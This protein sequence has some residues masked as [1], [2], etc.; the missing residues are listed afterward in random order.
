[1]NVRR[2]LARLTALVVVVAMPAMGMSGIASAKAGKAGPNCI[3]HPTKPKCLNASGG[4]S[5]TGGP[6]PQI[7]VQVDPQ[8]VVETGQSEVHIVIQVETLASFAGDSVNID[9]SQL[10]SSCASL[11][12]ESL[13]IGGPQTVPPITAVHLH[14]ISAVLDDDGN[15]TVV[16]NG[17]DCAPGTDVI[18]ADL[19][20]SPFLTALTTLTVA[21]PA[22]TP[23]GVS[24]HPQFGGLNQEV[25]TGDTTTSGDSDIYAVFYVE[26]NPVYA[27]QTVEIS[28]AQ[29]EARCIEGWVWEAGNPNGVGVGGPP[30]TPVLG[31]GANTNP[32]AS[33]I[34][35][36]DGN[37]V[38]IFKGA[39]CA[40]G[41]SQVIAD[42]LAG[43]HPTYTVQFTVLAP[44]VTI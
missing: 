36:D 20:V 27:E 16:A 33:T 4:G 26:T 43:T 44:Q 13:Q 17:T 12:F 10:D 29:L 42:V 31:V 41:P 21:P 23:E 25:E 30:N 22:V 32:P 2:S 8:P 28:S 38:F 9:S 18:E 19:E 6:P 24:V 3:K 5:G 11:T 37:A 1:V 7:T 34:L 15:V 39:S 35:D 40:S 14:R